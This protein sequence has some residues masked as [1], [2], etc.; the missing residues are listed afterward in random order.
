MVATVSPP[1]TTTLLAGMVV[2]TIPYHTTTKNK[3]TTV[4]VAPPYHTTTPMYFFF[5]FTKYFR[6]FQTSASKENDACFCVVVALLLFDR[7]WY[8]SHP[9]TDAHPH[10]QCYHHRSRERAVDIQ[11]VQFSTKPVLP[12]LVLL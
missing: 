11:A 6:V 10:T 7:V 5:R 3:R 1:P 9:Q 12:V 8:S 4:L 2:R